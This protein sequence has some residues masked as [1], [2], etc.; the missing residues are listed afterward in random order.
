A[1]YSQWR[2][3]TGKVQNGHVY[4]TWP[5]RIA[6]LVLVHATAAEFRLGGV[7][8]RAIALGVD[9]RVHR[10]LR[11]GARNEL[12]VPAPPSCMRGHPD[13]GGEASQPGG[14]ALGVGPLFW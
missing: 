5:N 9:E 6:F 12:A 14:A 3:D 11:G 10:V 1:A 2:T 4:D 8:E 13:V 7:D